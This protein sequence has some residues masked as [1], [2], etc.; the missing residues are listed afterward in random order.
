VAARN[1]RGY[2]KE[3]LVETTVTVIWQKPGFKRPAGPE[4]SL[5]PLI[6]TPHPYMY[7]NCPMGQ[8]SGTAT[9]ATLRED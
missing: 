6:Q 8:L 4:S 3:E 7:E 1:I 9:V 5:V 2:L